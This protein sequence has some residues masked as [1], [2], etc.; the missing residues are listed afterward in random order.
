MIPED[1]TVAVL[2]PAGMSSAQAVSFVKRKLGIK[3]A[4]HC[5]TL[6]PGA[7][8]VLKVCFG[9]ATK[10]SDFLMDSKK[11]YICEFTF[12]IETDTLD[13]YG[14]IIRE[15]KKCDVSLD[16]VRDILH[17]FIGKISQIPPVYSAI[18]RGGV[19]LYKSARKG[20]DVQ[21]EARDVEVYS[22]DILK[23]ADLSFLLRIECSKGTY[24][25]ALCRDMASLMGTC[26]YVS[27]LHRAY[28]S[29]SSAEECVSLEEISEKT[30]KDDYSFI[31]S[32]DEELAV[33]PR[34]ELDDYLFHIV[35]TG[36]PVDLKRTGEI[37]SLD[38][39]A[40]N[41][42][43]CCGKLIGLGI[44]RENSLVIKPMLYK[45]VERG[46]A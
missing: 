19:P 21:A 29:G 34:V 16:N 9:K 32:L 12:G 11:T 20:I 46:C 31:K 27:F 13:S 25:T 45:E 40:A 41:A 44:V 18:K 24:I 15:D 38:F 23:A 10:L 6:D 8:G 1:G 43:Y 2:K 14:S 3:K 7:S 33:L 26:G 37:N 5:G 17:C 28:A 30:V 42:V 39:S 22:I 35:T 36:T 4:G